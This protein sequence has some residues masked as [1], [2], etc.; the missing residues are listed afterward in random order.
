MSTLNGLWGAGALIPATVVAPMLARPSLTCERPCGA[1]SSA[2]APRVISAGTVVRSTQ[3]LAEQLGRPG[4]RLGGPG[5]GGGRG[6]GL[7]SGVEQDRGDVHARDPVDERVVG[8]GDQR[9]APAG[10]AL[11]E[12]D[13]PQR[14]GAVEPLGEE[15][16]GEP[17]E[18]LLIGRPGQGRVAYV[19]ARVEMRIIGPHRP[20]LIEGNVGQPLAVAR[21]Q[22]QAAEHVVDQLLRSRRF[23]LEHHHR[24]HVHVRGRVVLQVQEG[25]VQRGQAVGVGHMVDCRCCSASRQRLVANADRTACRRGYVARGRRGALARP[26]RLMLA[27]SPFG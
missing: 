22:V 27:A 1:R 13:L 6:H 5:H 20:A 18:R 8:L 11:H 2:R 15:P 4:Q 17:L 19:V 23:A 26:R 10:H 12:P 14:L 3:R 24:G 7:G 21:H 16:P 25:G 9:E